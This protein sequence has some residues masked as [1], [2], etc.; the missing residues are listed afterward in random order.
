MPI[1][2][3][4]NYDSALYIDLDFMGVEGKVVENYAPVHANLFN[5]FEDEVLSMLVSTLDITFGSAFLY[6]GGQQ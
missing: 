4:S 3:D 5:Y 6:I 2:R 1:C